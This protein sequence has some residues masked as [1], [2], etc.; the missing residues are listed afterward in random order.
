MCRHRVAQQ[1]CHVVSIVKRSCSHTRR[2][3]PRNCL[4]AAA[5][6]PF[7]DKRHHCD[8]MQIHSRLD[9]FCSQYGGGQKWCNPRRVHRL[10]PVVLLRHVRFFPALLA[11][12][13]S[14][15]APVSNVLVAG[16]NVCAGKAASANSAHFVNG[17]WN[18]SYAL[19]TSTTT[20]PYGYHSD[21]CLPAMA[22][23]WRV[24]LGAEF[25]VTSVVFRPRQDNPTVQSSNLE[26]T[27]ENKVFSLLELCTAAA[28]IVTPFFIRTDKRF[29]MQRFALQGL[30]VP[31]PLFS[32][33]LLR[34]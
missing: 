21:G 10:Q 27:F 4:R 12:T 20:P 32:P 11:R 16:T 13:L 30:L 24:D 2:H 29:H 1:H 25:N 23:W 14:C 6:K 17:E 7:G 8:Q 18:T 28:D 5:K 22:S 15:T 26:I 34:H 19:L 31:P 9:H 33:L 3:I